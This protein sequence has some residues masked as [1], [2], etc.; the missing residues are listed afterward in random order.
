[1]T[2]KRAVK[3]LFLV[4]KLQERAKR[5]AENG[6]TGTASCNGITVRYY[7]GCGRFGWFEDESGAISKRLAVK[8]L[9]QQGKFP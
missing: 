6:E 1:M 9:E 5:N 4:A 3:D 7:P 2:G 8:L